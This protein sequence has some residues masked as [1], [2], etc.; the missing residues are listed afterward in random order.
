MRWLQWKNEK[1]KVI[2]EFYVYKSH[3]LVNVSSANMD[4]KFKTVNRSYQHSTFAA[5]THRMTVR[6]YGDPGWLLVRLLITFG[7][8]KN[9]EDLAHE[10]SHVG[11][12]I[13]THLR[14]AGKLRTQKRIKHRL[15]ADDEIAACI[16]GKMNRV[17]NQWRKSGYTTTGKVSTVIPETYLKPRFV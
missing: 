13:A 5:I 16:V 2:V 11:H 7:G 9:D 10:L 4:R 6:R 15:A 8:M 1:V 3:R 17:L 12:T 14:K